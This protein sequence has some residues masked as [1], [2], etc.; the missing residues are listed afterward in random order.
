MNTIRACSGAL[1]IAATL[2]LV[3]AP[4]R[5]ESHLRPILKE[6]CFPCHGE[7]G[8]FK[9][10]LDVRLKRLLLKGGETGPAIV[11]GNP[12]A[13]L[14]LQKVRQGEMP[15]GKAKLPAT[16]IALIKEW[17]AQGA[18][19]ARPEPDDPDAA[20]ITEEERGFW[21]F[22]PIRDPAVPKHAKNPIDAF[23]LKRLHKEG[24]LFS[25]ESDK[26][27]LIRRAT[28]DLTGLPPSP[29]EISAFLNDIA[30][31]AFAKLIDRLLASPQYGERW[32]RHWLDVA[33][34]ADSEGYTEAD[35]ERLWSWRY[36]DYVIRA[37]NQDMPFDRFIREQL[38]GDEM[39]ERPY[40]NLSPEQVD[41][42]TATGFLRM[43]PDGTGSGAPDAK[44]AR[45]MV[46]ADT[47]K[48]V[49]TSLMGLTVGCAQCHNH[50][51]DPIPQADYYKL[52][53]IFEPALDWKNWLKPGKRRISI[54]TEANRRKA[55]EIEMAA[56]KVDAGRQRKIE[57]FINATLEWKLN[58][59]PEK[60]REP[61]RQAYKTP[62][63]KRKD[64]Q[65]KLL[66][67]HPSVSQISAGSLYLYDREYN[68]EI[69]KANDER[70]KKLAD[71]LEQ[72]RRQAL[73]AAAAELRDP[74]EAARKRAADKRTDEQKRLLAE[75]PGVAVNETSLEDFDA[76]AAAELKKLGARAEYFR[77][78]LSKKVLDDLARK[79]KDIRVTKPEEPFIRALSEPPGKAPVTY[80]FFR[81]DHEQ[82]K[83][84]VEPAE[85]SVVALTKNP[86]PLNDS[87]LPSTGRRLAF[88]KRLTDG[89][90]PL[91]AR[92]LV[93][94]FWLHHFGRGLVNTPGDFGKLGEVP[95]HPDLL[96]W[97]ATDFMKNGWQLKR[98]HRLIMTSQAYRQD[99]RRSAKLDAVDPDNRL[100]GRMSSRRLE[101]ETLRDAILA[102]S[103]R[104]N[105]KRF[106]KPVPVME[107][108]VGQFIIG[109]ENLDGERKPGKSIDLNGEGYRRSIY[110]QVRRSRILSIFD[111]FDAPAMEPNCTKRSVST[112]AL[113]ALMFM[114]NDF[115]V[116]QSR[117]M[118]ER[119][120]RAAGDRLDRQLA[121][122][123]ERTLGQEMTDAELARAK[124]FVQKQTVLFKEKKEKQPELTALANY[125][126]ALLSSNGFIYVD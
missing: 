4:V 99:S 70:K 123:W 86:I 120:R 56:K 54:F 124:T 41:K 22:Q 17:I 26:R 102:L 65:K 11:P 93:N 114:N 20:L 111:A 104:L 66:K 24:L 84:A 30:P 6:H 116:A 35:T 122:A 121:T 34:Y 48:I 107:D 81:G 77:G 7:D 12:D 68:I 115:V 43:A 98:L 58:A 46:M 90:H 38:A 2:S 100:L 8:T 44:L 13:S 21:A 67:E 109:K 16:D 18:M 50:R 106:G 75:H 94:R 118:A 9:G 19:T 82:P 52:R 39:V 87:G 60:L 59:L 108:E 95:S 88:A 10:G 64:E 37:F 28:F 91:T 112:T 110:V 15:K 36:R 69:G 97:L 45:N 125:C 51:Y 92:T 78:L 79:A 47:L 5:F 29:E 83:A 40:K 117:V 32:G 3:A 57:F 71:Y 103:G 96:D 53:A 76:A 73:N 49:S 14:L 42:L 105:P 55:G 85:L 23:L 61:L 113:Q 25:A 63:D 62:N 27:T 33:G 101:A 72:V 1:L 89:T 126:Q 74:L 119:M 80:V 31:N